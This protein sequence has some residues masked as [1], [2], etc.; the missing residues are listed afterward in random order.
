MR[1]LLLVAMAVLTG[2]AAGPLAQAPGALTDV[3]ERNKRTLQ[4][5]LSADSPEAAER[6]LS[7]TYRPRLLAWDT[8]LHPH[9]TVSLLAV[10]EDAA[11]AVIH[12]DND[13]SRLIGH[14]GWDGTLTVLFNPDGAITATHFTPTPGKNPSWGPYMDA[15]MPWL[16]EHRAAELEVVFPDHHLRQDAEGARTWARILREWRA[17]TGRAPVG[18]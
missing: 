15:A 2:C 13:F 3:Q 16:R 4:Q 17:A 8:S 10:N 6:V 1:G 14:P 11:I 5:Y 12:E 7:P 18:E 9:R